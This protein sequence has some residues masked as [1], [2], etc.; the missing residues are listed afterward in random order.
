MTGSN[1]LLAQQL[2]RNYLQI[3]RD[4]LNIKISEEFDIELVWAF[5]TFSFQGC[6]LHQ[7]VRQVQCWPIS[8]LYELAIGQIG[9]RWQQHFVNMITHQKKTVTRMFTIYKCWPFRNF[10]LDLNQRACWRS[11][12]VRNCMQL[13][14]D[15]HQIKISDEFDVDLCL[16]FINFQTSLRWNEC[17]MWISQN[18]PSPSC[19]FVHHITI[20][21]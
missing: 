9:S 15:V 2:L 17:Q 13:Y 5:W 7:N 12:L 8:D 14:R 21:E 19:S 16:T 20:L 10:N 11:Y 18:L 6:F 3:Y 1:T 4:F